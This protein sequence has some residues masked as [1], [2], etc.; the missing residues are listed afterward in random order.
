M[1]NLSIIV[2]LEKRLSAYAEGEVTRSNFVDFLS[3]SIHALEGIPL[4]VVNELRN[5][6]Y[7]IE[8]EGYFDE[9]GFEANPAS[10]Q[11]NLSTWLNS[12]KEKYCA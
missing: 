4:N 2:R 3:S 5:H 8:T 7:A 1:S 12:L 10:A 11:Q 9:E 6:E